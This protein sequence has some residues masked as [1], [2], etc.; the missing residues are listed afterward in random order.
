[1]EVAIPSKSG[2]SLT[3]DLQG[4]EKLGEGLSQS[5]LNRV[6]PSHLVK[7]PVLVKKTECRNP[8]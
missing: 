4:L 1:M 7:K 5:P 3:L 8:L 2:Q 6:N